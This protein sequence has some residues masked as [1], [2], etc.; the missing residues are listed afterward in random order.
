MAPKSLHISQ[1]IN[2]N[3]GTV[4]A[5]AS[6]PV[7][8]PLW[9]AGLSAG[10]RNEGGRWITDSPMGVVEVAF[11]G[12]TEHGVLDHDV[13]FPNGSVA[14]NP[15][16]VLRNGDGSEVVFTLYRKDDVTDEDFAR[17]VDMV[18]ADLRRLHDLLATEADATAIHPDAMRDVTVMI[19]SRGLRIGGERD[20]ALLGRMLFEFNSEFDQPE[21]SAAQI[22]KLAEPQLH[23][24]EIAVIFAPGDP[25]TG[26]AQLRYRTSLY[27]HGLACCLEEL[28]VR[29]A[30]RGT[31]IGGA[32][33]EA[34]MELA[35]AHGATHIDLNTTVD[36]RAARALYE[37][38]G[39]TN[40]ENGPGGPS[41]LYYEREL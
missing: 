5:F 36:D 11:V 26:F 1:T 14:H 16:R 18:R 4:I 17:D 20:A 10:I 2:R 3:T 12:P 27:A 8:L 9:A 39:F 25:P 19:S 37:R 35:R 40:E 15:L 7:N 30:H 28:W 41:M 38:C 23:S 24:G 21:P 6:D 13:T 31:G 34:T 22:A 32:L 33:L 29:P